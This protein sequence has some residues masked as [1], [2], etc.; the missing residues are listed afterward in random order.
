MDKFEKRARI[1]NLISL[2]FCVI[3]LYL[4][5]SLTIN[6]LVLILL[7]LQII[8]LFFGDVTDSYRLLRKKKFLRFY[9]LALF[10]FFFLALFAIALLELKFKLY[11]TFL[12][13]SFI[14]DFLANKI[15]A[16]RLNQNTVKIKKK[17][18]R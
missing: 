3:S 9:T 2:V 8:H 15:R 4:N 17:K 10:V 7:A 14:P 6:I 12:L 13:L 1:F 18:K 5:L 16:D 11:F